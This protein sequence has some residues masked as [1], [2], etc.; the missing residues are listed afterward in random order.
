M[1]V[2]DRVT[3]LR[4]GAHVSTDPKAAVSIADLVNRM[5]GRAL[6]V[7]HRARSRDTAEMLRLNDVSAG[8]AR[9]VSFAVRA[10]EIVGLAG[11]VGAGR[12]DVL[13]AIVGITKV[14]SG[15]I[16]ATASTV[17]LPEDR[18]RNGIVPT[19]SLRENL[20]LPCEEIWLDQQ[21]ERRDAADWIDRVR[22]RPA[23]TEA[24]ITSLS[25]GNQQK[26]LL[27]R[28]LRHA[29]QLL[30]LDEPTAGVD[31]G[32]KVEI[33][34]E[35]ARLADAGVAV[36]LASSELP[37]L[38]HLCDRILAMYAG[39]IVGELDASEATEERVAALI[40]GSE[41]VSGEAM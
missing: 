41:R 40:T 23:S 25:G 18:G 17:L 37:E 32:A 8:L 29:P 10:G 30:L 6:T 4:D 2:A 26:L 38:L 27:A 14:R 36:L 39:R 35:I 31:V 19:L 28:A 20:L 22:I 7:S 1:Q 33:H 34:A 16:S 11:L 24:P 12:S 13:E 9:D 3:V 5:V 21:Q 15:T